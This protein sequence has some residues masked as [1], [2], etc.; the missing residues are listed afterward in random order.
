M[1]SAISW[2]SVLQRRKRGMETNLMTSADVA[3]LLQVSAP[4][5]SRWRSS[6]TGPPFINLNGIP[7]Y[8]EADLQA[9]IKEKRA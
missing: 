1:S 8:R 6:R 4:T 3:K 2:V 7:R 5:L 9:W